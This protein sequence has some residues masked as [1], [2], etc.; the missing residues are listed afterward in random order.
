MSEMD[1]TLSARR[2]R[3]LYRAEHRGTKE[4][5]WL[6]GKYAAAHLAE[7]TAEELTAFEQLLALPDPDLEHWITR[8]DVEGPEG[9]FGDLILRLRRFHGLGA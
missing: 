7:M 1:E 5:D 9:A 6:L 4:M 3:A 8:S 2:R